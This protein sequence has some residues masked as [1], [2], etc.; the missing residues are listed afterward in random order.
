[1]LVP[2]SSCGVP[3][4]DDTCGLRPFVLA[5]CFRIASKEGIRLSI[6]VSTALLKSSSKKNTQNILEA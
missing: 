4:Y 1:M 6:L 3:R 2:T 5:N